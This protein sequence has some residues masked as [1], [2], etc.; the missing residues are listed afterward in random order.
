MGGGRKGRR[1]LG[2]F[3]F[4]FEVGKGQKEEVEEEGVVERRGGEKKKQWRKG[5]GG[6]IRQPRWIEQ[7]R[8]GEEK[9]KKS[10]CFL[11]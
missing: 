10:S 5:W 11:E 4:F 2:C 9:R 1:W 6:S 7:K 8:K 3:L